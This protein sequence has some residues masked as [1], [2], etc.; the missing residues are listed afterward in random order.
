MS[1]R[2][3]IDTIDCVAFAAAIEAAAEPYDPNITYLVGGTS[4]KEHVSSLSIINKI[5]SGKTS[6]SPPVINM[7]NSLLFKQREARLKSNDGK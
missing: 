1:I 7:K 5:V 2:E 4:K 6:R 3:S